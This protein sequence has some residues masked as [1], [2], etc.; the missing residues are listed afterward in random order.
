MAI[1]RRTPLEL[2]WKWQLSL[3]ANRYLSTA[4]RSARKRVKEW[5]GAAKRYIIGNNLRYKDDLLNQFETRAYLTKRELRIVLLNHARKAKSGSGHAAT[6]VEGRKPGPVPFGAILQ[7]VLD[8]KGL[9]IV[10]R[11]MAFAVARNITEDIEREGYKAQEGSDFLLNT[12]EQNARKWVA[13]TARDLKATR[14]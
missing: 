4:L 6:T 11:E 5:E 1:Q 12:L 14:L 13:A 8:S 2:D 3:A 9:G 7:W 10:D